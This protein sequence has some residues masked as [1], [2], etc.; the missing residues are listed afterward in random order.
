MPHAYYITGDTESGITQAIGFAGKELGINGPANPD[1]VVLRYQHFSVDDARRLMDVAVA[2]PLGDHKAIIVSAERFFH[3]AQNA[4]LKLFEEP[5]ANVTL[6]LVIPSEGTLL[7]TLRSRLCE[8]P[9]AG[10]PGNELRLSALG[11]EFLAG[12][13]EERQKL[14]EKLVD[15]SKSDKDEEKQRARIDAM[16]LAEDLV[17]TA[18]AGKAGSRGKADAREY[19]LLLQD[20]DRFL[21]LLHT[22]SAPIKL[23]FEHL[24]LVIPKSFTTAQV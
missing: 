17:R 1:L 13:D 23:I 11:Q 14:V 16:R 9:D 8:L 24:L 19:R 3:E 12:S 18:Y 7:A 15:R 10:T 2:A 20:L 4:L 6:I 5:P 21:P 22:R